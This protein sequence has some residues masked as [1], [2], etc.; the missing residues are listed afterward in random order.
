[1]RYTDQKKFTHHGFEKEIFHH[2]INVLPV[3]EGYQMQIFNL[4]QDLAELKG[5]YNNLKKA[6][7]HNS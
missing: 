5:K 4:I 3:I 2:Y 7:F 6:K 1:M